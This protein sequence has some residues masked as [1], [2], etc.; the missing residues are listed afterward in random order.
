MWTKSKKLI[1][2]IQINKAGYTATSCGQV[3]RGGNVRFNSFRLVL[4][5]GPT[6][7]RTDGRTDGRTDKAS[8]RVACPQLKK[9]Y[10]FFKCFN[11]KRFLILHRP[12]KIV[13]FIWVSLIAKSQSVNPVTP[14]V[15]KNSVEILTLL[16][17]KFD[18]LTDFP[19]SF[20]FFLI[21]FCFSISRPKNESVTVTSVAS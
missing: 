9:N 21:Y 11:L 16:E 12:E 3:G 2:Y 5:D 4:T 6:N 19:I 15:R 17:F 7:Q 13:W 1:L 10:P 20:S 18:C 14:Q 8:Y